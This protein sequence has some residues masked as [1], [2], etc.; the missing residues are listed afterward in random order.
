MTI[1]W[2]TGAKGFIGR[3]IAKSLAN[4]GLNVSGIDHSAWTDT[5]STKWGLSYCLY[6]DV[7]LANLDRLAHKTG[8]PEQIF[9]LAGGSSV[10]LSLQTPEQD[11][12]LSVDSTAQILEW[13]HN[14]APQ[15]HLVLASSAAIYGDG[16]LKP[17]SE[18]NVIQPYSPYGY[19]KRIAELLFESYHKNFG[20]YTAIVRLFSVYGPELRKQLLWDLCTKVKN[21]PREIVL[22]GSGQE[23]RDW[24]HVQDAVQYLIKAASLTDTGG[25][26]VN[27]GS[28]NA[29]TVQEIAEYV[30][31]LLGTN[32]QIVFS[33]ISRPG[34]PQYLVA[35]TQLAQ[36]MGLLPTIDW[37]AGIK[38]YVVWFQNAK[39][40]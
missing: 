33:G 28:G 7:S 29:V 6:G 10:G 19:H 5:E 9:H 37:H 38:E 27:G 12:R 18:S 16:Y 13:A 23:K 20:L 35:D 39:G 25:F 40:K 24:F 26:V 22:A 4:A 21:K 36:S 34:D 17:I 15:T 1:A 14:H 11:F 31:D 30:R 3:H 32:T 8:I 2:V